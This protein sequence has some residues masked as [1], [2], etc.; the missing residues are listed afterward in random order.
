VRLRSALL[1]LAVV[2]AFAA[3]AAAD[4]TVVTHY[5]LVNGDTL[6]RANYYAR[7]KVRVT[8]PDGK[9][10]MFDQKSDSVTV[11]DHVGRR[12]WTGRRS[13]ADSVATKIMLANREGVPE[14]ATADPVAW[15]E[16]L[17][18]F[19]DSIKV[20]PTMK[21]KKIA[22]YT[23]D[24]WM[25]TA[26]HY[27]TNERWIARS[28]YFPNYGPEMQKTVLATIKDPMGRALMRLMIGMREKE[29]MTLSGSATFKTLSRE[30]SFSFEA[31][32]VSSKPIPNSAWALPAGYTRVTL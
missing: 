7:K 15:G 8:S 20:E 21:Q 19:N 30:G 9:E 5:T 23:C 22:G 1:A 27:L 3:P 28:I 25:L 11:I 29:G 32:K 24:Q 26:G 14:E 16:K 6:T 18:A 13:Q 10:F 4:Y 12:Y 17:Q 31:L 2:V